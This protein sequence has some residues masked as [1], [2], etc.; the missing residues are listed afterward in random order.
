MFKARAM[1]LAVVGLA[2]AVA[3]TG[4]KSKK[5]AK[6]GLGSDGLGPVAPL[7]VLGSDLPPERPLGMGEMRGQFEPVYFDYDSSQVNASE[8]AKIA[9]VAEHLKANAS[10]P[11]I[12]EGHCDERGSAEYNLAL[13]ERRALAVRAYL[14]GLGVDGSRVHSKS[15]G[16]EMPVAPGHDDASWRQNRRAEFVVGQ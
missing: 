15:L 2:A 14:I 13:G 3:V 4:C 8:H 5:A 9:A 16:E 1:M 12:V 7:E 6:A 10:D 11:M